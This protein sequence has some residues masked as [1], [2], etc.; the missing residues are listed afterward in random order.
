MILMP[1]SGS[2]ASAALQVHCLCVPEL[3]VTMSTAE[4]WPLPF[5][6]LTDL[7][8]SKILLG[9][10]FYFISLLLAFLTL[11]TSIDRMERD[12]TGY[13]LSCLYDV[14][15]L[16]RKCFKKEKTNNKEQRQK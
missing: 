1:K 2:S 14:V 10:C 8:S 16:K 6:T 7:L 11:P 15:S 3:E 9:G 4:V 5:A 13:A 12:T